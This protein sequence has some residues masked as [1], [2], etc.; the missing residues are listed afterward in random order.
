MKNNYE[1]WTREFLESWKNLDWEKTLETLDKT[2]IYYENPIDEPCKDF[3][4]VTALWNVV[5]TNQRDIDYQFE[6]IAFDENFCM[7]NFQ[8]TR[9]MTATNKKQWIDGVFQISLNSENKCTYFKQW[10][11]TKEED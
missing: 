6:I 7:V 1:T 11:F 3:E 4:E 10:R 9:T 2:V 5:A 8:M